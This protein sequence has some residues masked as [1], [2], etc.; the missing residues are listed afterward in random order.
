MRAQVFVCWTSR[1]TAAPSSP[2]ARSNP[3]C[4]CWVSPGAFCPPGG[5]QGNR[6][7]YRNTPTADFCLSIFTSVSLGGKNFKTCW[8]SLR[9]KLWQFMEYMLTFSR[10][11][12]SDWCWQHY[13]HTHCVTKN[14]GAKGYL[15]PLAWSASRLT[16]A[17]HCLPALLLRKVGNATELTVWL[18]LI[19]LW[20]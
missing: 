16:G 8:P 4:S 17:C 20:L 9:V 14:S 1:G 6:T 7:W 18:T 12:W 19:H 2:A 3:S 10:V 11:D 5:T 15:K 13:S